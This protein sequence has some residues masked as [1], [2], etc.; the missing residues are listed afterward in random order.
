MLLLLQNLQ[1]GATP[2]TPEPT[3]ESAGAPDYGARKKRKRNE[4]FR[5]I[6]EEEQREYREALKAPASV[7]RKPIAAIVYDEEEDETLMLLLL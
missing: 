7:Q 6:A 1:A 3:P 4:R 2:P 5:Q